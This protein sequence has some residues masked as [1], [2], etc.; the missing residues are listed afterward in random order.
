M[1]CFV[2]FRVIW[3]AE[4]TQQ[5]VGILSNNLAMRLGHEFRISANFLA[6]IQFVNFPTL[7]AFGPDQIDQSLI[8]QGS[9]AIT[10][11]SATSWTVFSLVL[12][13]NKSFP[14]TPQGSRS[15]RIL[16]TAFEAYEIK[17][18]W[19]ARTIRAIAT[20]FSKRIFQIHGHPARGPSGCTKTQSTRSCSTKSRAWLLLATRK[21]W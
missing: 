21:T 9:R 7:D 17:P 12:G 1:P 8:G 6:N 18:L 19:S 11:Y 14:S 10:K 20:S 4:L 2:L 13:T 15:T 16:E 3:Q 5:K